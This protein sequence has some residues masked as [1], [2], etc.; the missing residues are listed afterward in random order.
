MEK[1]R[2]TYVWAASGKAVGVGGAGKRWGWGRDGP[3]RG[4]VR[5]LSDDKHGPVRAVV[6]L[7]SSTPR[8]PKIKK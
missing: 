4:T 1:G 7:P 5:R 6:S 2:N 3:S 8:E